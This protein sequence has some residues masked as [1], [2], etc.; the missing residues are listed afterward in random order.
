M[1]VKQVKILHC[2][3]I[4]LG[5]E[6]TTLGRSSV[7][8]RA[9]IKNTFMNI[10]KLCQEDQVELLLIAGDLFDSVHV[11]ENTLEEIKDG[12]ASLKDTVVVIAPGNHDPYTLDSPYAKKDFWSENVIIFKSG[13]EKVEFENLGIR[14]WG[15]AFTETYVTASML[16]NHTVPKDE[17]I[18]ICVIHGELVALNQRSNYN[19]ITE[20]Q[21]IS[22]GMDYVALGHIHKQTDILKAGNTYYAYSGCL[23]GRGFDELDEKGVYI[24]IVSKG[25]CRLLYRTLC[26]R[27]NVELHVD[28]SDA[29]NSRTAADIVLQKIESKYGKAYFNNL[30]KVILEGMIDDDVSI[31]IEDIKTALNEVFFVKI[32]D[33]TSIKTNFDKAATESTLKSVFIRKMTERIND[34]KPEEKERLNTALRLGLKAFLGEVQYSED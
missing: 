27:M 31:N 12:F 19:P 10:I 25:Y 6:L 24:G 17:L 33:H 8:R 3:D 1:I 7:A 26:K 32:K 21:L 29:V 5:A 22:S 23:E 20:K 14:L 30:Y 34:A 11:Q 18:N 2:A 28:I 15:A 16:K 4:H 13:L 9:E